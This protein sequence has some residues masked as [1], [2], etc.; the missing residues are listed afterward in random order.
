MASCKMNLGQSQKSDD[1]AR[2]KVGL[3][4]TGEMGSK[5]QLGLS[6]DP[7]DVSAC[8][9]TRVPFGKIYHAMILAFLD[10]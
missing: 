4:R 5:R 1:T 2:I 10:P 7:V 9:E 8:D 6:A 3:R